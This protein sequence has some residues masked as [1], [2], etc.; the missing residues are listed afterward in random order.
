M[1]YIS[2]KVFDISVIQ[3]SKIKANLKDNYNCSPGRKKSNE[4]I[5]HHSTAHWGYGS[6]LSTATN[7]K[8]KDAF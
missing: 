1:F 8:E 5:I 4:H 3:V 2:L 7:T 6:F